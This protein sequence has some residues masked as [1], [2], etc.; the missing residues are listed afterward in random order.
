MGKRGTRVAWGWL[1]LAAVVGVVV[2]IATARTLGLC[3][4][5]VPASTA[6]CAGEWPVTDVAALAL[7]AA[8]ALLSL[9]C[10]RR[11]MRP[12]RRARRIRRSQ[13]ESTSIAT[14]PPPTHVPTGV[15]EA[16]EVPLPPRGALRISYAPRPDGR[17]DAGEVVW[18]WV[19]YQEDPTHGK[20][21]PLLIIGRHDRGHVLALRLTS[22]SSGRPTQYAIGA[23]AW[24]REGR[25]SFVDLARLYRVH[26]TGIRREA[27]PLP[28]EVF[29]GVAQ[30]L[31]RRYGWVR[32][33]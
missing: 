20:D 25:E 21:R 12:L 3:G 9:W 1:L 10:L 19:P 29:D 15:H 6:V 22:K 16:V 31:E 23:G 2:A 11:A 17:A 24:D 14:P 32:A 18:A 26:H 4:A 5:P 30:V 28:R 33:D 13:R 8:W 7:W 27:A